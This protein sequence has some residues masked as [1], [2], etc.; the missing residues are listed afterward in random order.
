MERNRCDGAGIHG[1]KLN[2]LGVQ[3]GDISD[4]NEDVWDIEASGLQEDHPHCVLGATQ[5][6]GIRC[7]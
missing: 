2:D 7:R 1:F 4:G 5:V 3:L 6:D